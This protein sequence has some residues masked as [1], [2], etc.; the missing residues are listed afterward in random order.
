M[1]IPPLSLTV[2]GSRA[3]LSFLVRYILHDLGEG[4]DVNCTAKEAFP[5]DDQKN[6]VDAWDEVKCRMH[7]Q[8]DQVSHL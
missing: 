1:Q 7:R 6:D 3:E 5:K 8:E 4:V 2:S